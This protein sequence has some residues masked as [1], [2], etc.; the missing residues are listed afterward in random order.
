[1]SLMTYTLEMVLAEKLETVVS[2]GVANTR[3]RD[4]YD[5][6]LLWKLRGEECD[7]AILKDA[8]S[9]T[10]EKRGSADRMSRWAQVLGQVEQDVQMLA[11]WSKY[12][13]RNP[14]VA[15]ITLQECCETA[16]E[17]MARMG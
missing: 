4:F 6:H 5:I 14:Y 17:V 10:C 2:R 12:A 3:P 11:L 1:M 16:R 15:G 13:K 7:I 8:V 9:A